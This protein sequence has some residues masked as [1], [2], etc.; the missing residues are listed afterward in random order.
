M[1]TD[2]SKMPPD[3]MAKRPPL[4]EQLP[5]EGDWEFPATNGNPTCKTCRWW[6]FPMAF[7]FHTQRDIPGQCHL[8]PDP[9]WRNRNHWCG[10]HQYR[11][12]A[13]ALL[14][15]Q[16][17]Q[18]PPRPGADGYQPNITLIHRS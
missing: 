5:V 4:L 17:K 9:A 2:N 16:E 14:E 15:Q 1:S 6:F 8:M 10:Q 18:P 11:D 7:D 13:K 3:E 12:A